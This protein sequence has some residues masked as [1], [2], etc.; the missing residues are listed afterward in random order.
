M[1]KKPS[2]PLLRKSPGSSAMEVESTRVH[3]LADGRKLID[4]TMRRPEDGT[5]QVW[6]HCAALRIGTLAQ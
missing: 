6:Q 2:A 4:V 1:L 5:V 3:V